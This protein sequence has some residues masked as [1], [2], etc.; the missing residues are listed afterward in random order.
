MIMGGGWGDSAQMPVF[1]ADKGKAT[2]LMNTDDYT[3]DRSSV[4]HQNLQ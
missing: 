3:D 4:R 1:P 2:T